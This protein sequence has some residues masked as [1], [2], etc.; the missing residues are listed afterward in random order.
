MANLT[1]SNIAIYQS[2]KLYIEG[3]ECPFES[4]SISYGVGGIPE[5]II[6]LV[7]YH[8]LRKLGERTRVHLYFL[9]PVDGQYRLLFDGE[10]RGEGYIRTP[11][12]RTL[13][14][15]V[16][17][18]SHYLDEILL[19]FTDPWTFGLGALPSIRAGMANDSDI[20]VEATTDLIL[21]QYFSKGLTD[22][23][24]KSFHEFFRN[25]VTLIIGG[26]TEEEKK[27]RE[28]RQTE[29]MKFFINKAGEWNL[30]DR[31][32]VLPASTGDSLPDTAFTLQD[33]VDDE[34]LMKFWRE[35]TIGTAGG[36][37][38]IFQLFNEIFQQIFYVPVVVPTPY[39]NG[40][41]QQSILYKPQ[42]LFV[43]PPLCN[44]IWPSM[45]DS[46]SYSRDFKSLPTRLYA[47]QSNAFGGKEEITWAANYI[48]APSSELQQTKIIPGTNRPYNIDVKEAFNTVIKSTGEDKVGARLGVHMENDITSRYI[49]WAELSGL[50]GRREKTLKMMDYE[51]VRQRLQS[52][53]S[54]ISMV[55]NPYIVPGFPCLIVDDPDSGMHVY[56]YVMAVTHNIHAR[57][58][59]HTT[60]DI[61][62][63]RQYDDAFVSKFPVADEVWADEDVVYKG[64]FGIGSIKSKEAQFNP[65]GETDHA[66][67]PQLIEGQ[68]REKDF[69]DFTYNAYARSYR[70]IISKDEYDDSGFGTDLK[71]V[72]DASIQDK[73]KTYRQWIVNR[74]AGSPPQDSNAALPPVSIPTDAP[75]VLGDVQD[76]SSLA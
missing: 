73:V 13:T 66:L 22:V 58:G 61:G 7:P 38:S 23:K 46:F 52:V 8:I 17:H 49:K 45:Y 60:A 33:F 2:Y 44:V 29:S 57:G 64:I 48:W 4:A 32:A 10:I 5:M 1:T 39:L 42:S 55:F 41:T 71:E 59:S 69:Y 50:P 15:S 9:D 43:S 36:I 24:D 54:S 20:S 28:A 68:I 62:Y 72:Y 11:S 31:I 6:Q 18:V 30:F 53:S 47:R 40:E 19:S 37:Y 26:K 35:H 70:P 75:L 16:T 34:S 76:T 56:G 25:F 51:L 63:L 21:N 65:T 74:V 14:Y 67:I 3:E 27:A 12:S